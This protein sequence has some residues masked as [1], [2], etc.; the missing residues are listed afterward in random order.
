MAQQP[1][2]GN[3]G[4]RYSRGNNTMENI[5]CS[6]NYDDAAFVYQ[7][8]F[9]YNVSKVGPLDFGELPKDKLFH[10]L[11]VKDESG[12]RLG[13]LVYEY[14]GEN[15]IYVSYLWL[16][17]ALR[18]HGIGLKLLEMLKEEARNKN[19]IRITLYTSTFQAPEFYMKAGFSLFKKVPT[20]KR[21]DYDDYYFE[22]ILPPEVAS[23]KNGNKKI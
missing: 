20:P 13:G 18:G 23:G 9:D 22:Y 15:E 8:L 21:P 11:I 12:N 2:M 7:H 17:Q 19:C 16:S 6:D 14:K 5:F 1:C 3:A 10:T 4:C